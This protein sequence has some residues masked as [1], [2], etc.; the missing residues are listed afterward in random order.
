MIED[1][2]GYQKMKSVFCVLQRQRMSKK[3]HQKKIMR[4]KLRKKFLF[5]LDNVYHPFIKTVVGKRYILCP[6]STN[7]KKKVKKIKKQN[8]KTNT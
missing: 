7:L 4:K 2:M 1:D 6:L 5:D 3:V 8:I